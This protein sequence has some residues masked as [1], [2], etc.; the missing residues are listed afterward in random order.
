VLVGPAAAWVSFWP[1]VAMTDVTVATPKERRPRAGG[2]SWVTRT[3]PPELVEQRRGLRYTTPAL[4]ALDLCSTVGGDGI[5]TALR[6][7]AATLAGMHEALALTGGRNGNQ[8]RRRLLLDSRDEPWSA[9][10]RLLHRLLRQAG[11]T[12]WRANMAVPTLGSVYYL[13]VAFDRQKVAIEVDGRLH[14]DDR[15]V[16]ESDR[17]RQN[18]LV[19][20]GW[21]VLR[22]TWL[23]LTQHPE[24]VLQTI[25]RALDP[26]SP[27]Q[28]MSRGAPERDLR[29]RR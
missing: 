9:A 8:E 21:T 12:G 5:D 25:Q 18:Q 22:F 2:F 14:E 7:R 1:R 28:L 17:W 13:D 24:L 3:I 23:M 29:G 27:V 19:L 6:M 4:T 10:E 26:L 20:Q 16:F 11:I 15:T